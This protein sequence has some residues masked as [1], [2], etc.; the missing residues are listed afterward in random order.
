MSGKQCIPRSDVTESASL[1]GYLWIP[2]TYDVFVGKE[3]KYKY[4][5]VKKNIL[6]RAVIIIRPESFPFLMV[7]WHKDIKKMV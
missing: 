1:S 5:K 6:Y 4:F 7:V 2:V 3:E